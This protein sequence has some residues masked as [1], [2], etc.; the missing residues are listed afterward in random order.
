MD[1]H[2]RRLH[3]V[4]EDP[5]RTDVIDAV[6]WDELLEPMTGDEPLPNVGLVVGDVPLGLKV[7]EVLTRN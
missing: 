5:E 4:A 3:V 1:E 6:L 2:V 7:E